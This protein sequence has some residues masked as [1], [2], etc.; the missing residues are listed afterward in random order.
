M[1]L[2]D[3]PSET[4]LGYG[5]YEGDFLQEYFNCERRNILISLAFG[6]THIPSSVDQQ[7]HQDVFET[8]TQL[9][10]TADRLKFDLD[11]QPYQKPAHISDEFS[12]SKAGKKN[13][14][15]PFLQ[16]VKTDMEKFASKLP[17]LHVNR[18]ENLPE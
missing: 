8:E 2:E 18:T 1:F 5:Q 6:S 17:I 16:G 7:R 13:G 4:I 9:I 12:Q 11:V 15:I 14:S 10:A 3:H